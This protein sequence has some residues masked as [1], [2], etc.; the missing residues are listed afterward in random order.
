M[1]GDIFS[2]GFKEIN[3]T[4]PKC[5]H[6]LIKNKNGLITCFNFDL[7]IMDLET[8]YKKYNKKERA[9]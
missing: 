3:E 9:I 1:K 7:G 6:K 4:C 5:K 8:F 2:N